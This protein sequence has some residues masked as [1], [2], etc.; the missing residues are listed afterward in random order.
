MIETYC[1]DQFYATI[2][3]SSFVIIYFTLLYFIGLILRD[4]TH[5]LTLKL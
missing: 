1:F 5:E 3:K 4:N 2:F